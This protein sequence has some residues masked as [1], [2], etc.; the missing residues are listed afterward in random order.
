MAKNIFVTGGAGYIG[1]HTCVEL[2]K[3]NHKITIFDNLSNSSENVIKRIEMLSN[4]KV[5]FVLGDIKTKN[6]L[7]EAVYYCQPDTVLHFAGLKAVA[8][9]VSGPLD[10][11][12]VNVGGTVN[13]LNAMANVG[14]KQ[15]VFSSSATV[16]DNQIKPPYRETDLTNPASPYGRTKLAS[17]MLIEDWVNSCKDH[18]SVVLRY[19]NPVGAHESGLIGENPKGIP[20]NLMPF[21]SQVAQKK[22]NCLHIFGNDY[23][24]RDGTGERDFIHVVDLAFGHVRSIEEIENLERFQILNLGTGQ[25]TTVLELVKSFEKSN[26][27]NLP[28]KIVARRPGDIAKSVADPTRAS[29][30]LDFKCKKT[31]ED[32]CLDTWNWQIKNPRGYEV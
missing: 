17:E 26:N 25:G 13:I 30:I 6:D 20:N 28:L 12:E 16:Y 32:M 3:Q 8:D 7:L 2:L 18:R 21:I 14:C 27:M 15:I 23:E 29:A 22:L 11:Y 31:L 19:F 4:K 9:S 1:S 5:H 24:T 10:F